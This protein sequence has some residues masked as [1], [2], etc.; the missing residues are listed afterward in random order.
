[1]QMTFVQALVLVCYV[2]HVFR[3]DRVASWHLYLVS[4][5]AVVELLFTIAA[6]VQDKNNRK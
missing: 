1:M 2:C 4:V 3:P 5:L 6:S